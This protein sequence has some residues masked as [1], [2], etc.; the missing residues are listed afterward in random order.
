MS[1]IRDHIKV[2]VDVLEDAGL[3]VH[4][5]RGPVDPTKNAPY[6]VVYDAGGL[7]LD[8]SACD[9]FVEAYVAIQITSVG[10]SAESS[11]LIADKARDVILAGG[12]PPPPGRAW[13]SKTRPADLDTTQPTQRDEDVTPAMFYTV[14]IVLLMSGPA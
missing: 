8:G 3:S 6:C 14:T 7:I 4:H 10:V 12:Y 2:V 1:I 9:P 5:G 13:L 11:E